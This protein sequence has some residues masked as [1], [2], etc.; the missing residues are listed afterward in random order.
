MDRS[1]DPL[2]EY[3]G[4][5]R[6]VPLEEGIRDAYDTFKRLLAAG[7]VSAEKLS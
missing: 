4:D 6:R 1:D 5:Y 7:K 2:R 3:I